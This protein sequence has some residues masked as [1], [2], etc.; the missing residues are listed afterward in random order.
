MAESS[1]GCLFPGLANPNGVTECKAPAE[2]YFIFSIFPMRKHE[3]IQ[4]GAWVFSEMPDFLTVHCFLILF[5]NSNL[6]NIK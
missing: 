6:V 4:K 3:G 5:I 1:R 2:F